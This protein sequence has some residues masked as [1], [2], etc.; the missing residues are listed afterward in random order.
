[1]SWKAYTFSKVQQIDRFKTVYKS[2]A[3]SINLLCTCLS[4]AMLLGQLTIGED[5]IS[6]VILNTDCI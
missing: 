5:N 6:Y 2:I 4:Q 1:M 3:F